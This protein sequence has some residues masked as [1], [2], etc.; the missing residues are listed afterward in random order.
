MSSGPIFNA[1]GQVIGIHGRAAG[2]EVSGKV[3]IN[4]GIPI[5]L[6]LQEA[7]KTGLN[8]QALGLKSR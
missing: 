3:G 4:S 7:S 2:N 5:A 8:L 1:Q 6:F